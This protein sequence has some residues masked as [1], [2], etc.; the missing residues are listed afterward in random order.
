MTISHSVLAQF[1]R[2][3]PKGCALLSL[4][5]TS[6]LKVYPERNIL[7]RREKPRYLHDP[8]NPEREASLWAA[9][10]VKT[11]LDLLV[12][13]GIGM[14]WHWKALQPCLAQNQNRHL[15]IIEDDLAIISLF[16]RSNRAEEL[17]N[18]P[19]T[20]LLYIGDKAEQR[21]AFQTIAWNSYKKKT[22]CVASP[23]Y[24]QYRQ[25]LF[26]QLFNE[27]IVLQQDV[28]SVLDEFLT[29]GESQL[30]NFG[31][32]LFYWR[33]SRSANSLYGKFKGY[34]AIVV[35]AGPSLDRHID[36]LKN[37]SS[38][39]LILSGGSSM[40]ALLQAGIMPHFGAS[41]DPN[42]MQYLR[43]RQAQPFALPIFY[44]SRALYEA[45]MFQKGP[46]FYVR[47]G[48]GYPIIEW[49]EDQLGVQGEALDGGNSVSNMLVEIAYELGCSPI[50]MVG[51]DLSY[52]N[53]KRYPES[54]SEALAAQES[55]SISEKANLI[56]TI[57][58]SGKPL[59]TEAKWI[60]E[61][62]WLE[63]FQKRHPKCQLLNT[64]LNGLPLQGITT[65]SLKEAI[66]TYCTKQ[67]DIDSLVHL[68]IEEAPK[69]QFT[70]EDLSKT[71]HTI[72]DS[73]QI[74][75]KLLTQLSA[76]LRSTK[77]PESPFIVETLYEI[78]QQIAHN[79]ALLPFSMMH[80]KL[81][82]M[83][84]RLLKHDYNRNDFLI[85][86]LQAR[87]QLLLKAV[88]THLSFFFSI[89]AWAALNGHFL[90]NN[91]HAVPWPDFLKKPPPSL[92]GLC[93]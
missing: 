89:S 15:M 19:Q 3:N 70:N 24:K 9:P 21:D 64:A 73:L 25:P 85:H 6:E 34:P 42:P 23:A 84:E 44:R 77:D 57:S 88:H 63:T 32:N 45:L 37:L 47:G 39:A 67:L 78:E 11:N 60:T 28:S 91:L 69:I 81:I 51:Y 49:F 74:T 40:N 38:Q 36:E 35:A 43:L 56:E 18:D 54:I 27:L 17:F 61:A 86:A 52:T 83:Q 75:Q 65:V 79:E 13:F 93:T 62:K 66:Q 90:P 1:E 72:S 4:V 12:I 92:K 5:D 26:D 53:D 20:T 16:L 7:D 59:Q 41:V 14:G 50:I 31:R 2:L 33:N 87:C 80:Q 71:I 68:N 76:E 46:L 58:S 55:L 8:K 10:I 48:D 29:F 22:A 82:Q 30:H